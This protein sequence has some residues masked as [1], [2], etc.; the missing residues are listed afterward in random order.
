MTGLGL[1]A[2]RVGFSL[3]F[4]GAGLWAMSGARLALAKRREWVRD[5]VLASGTVVD[6]RSR[7]PSGDPAYRKVFAP[8][9]SFTT[10][11]GES[12]SFTSSLWQRPNPYAVGQEVRV[13]Y[14]PR[15]PASAD[16]D[17]ATTSWFVPGALLL[18]ALVTLL[19]ASLPW[20]L[21]PP[22]SR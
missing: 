19:V 5:G 16:I 9:V 21:G 6:L 7:S 14:L 4:G 17:A 13:R 1:L 2:A 20:V 8:V 18:M 10:R 22:S 15:D 12:I 11:D 3:L